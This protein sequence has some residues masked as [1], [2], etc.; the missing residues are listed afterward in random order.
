M[1]TILFGA[2][3]GREDGWRY[4]YGLA[5]LQLLFLAPLWR[6]LPE[7]LAGA[8]RESDE[9]EL[10]REAL[11]RYSCY[12]RFKAAVRSGI[13]PL[14]LLVTAYPK[15]AAACLFVNCNNGFAITPSAVLKIK[16]LQDVHGLTPAAVSLVVLC[17]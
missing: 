17:S 6:M 11:K 10:R 14:R 8:D 9:D 7:K 13:R 5:S 2:V 16:Q 12:R 1:A 4:L 3:G 15:R